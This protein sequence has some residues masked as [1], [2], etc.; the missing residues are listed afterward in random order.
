MPLAS[1]KRIRLHLDSGLCHVSLGNVCP[2]AHTKLTM[3]RFCSLHESIGSTI[4]SCMGQRARIVGVSFTLSLQAAAQAVTGGHEAVLWGAQHPPLRSDLLHVSPASPGPTAGQLALWYG[5]AFSHAP[6][7][8]LALCMQLCLR[9]QHTTM[10]DHPDAH[11]HTSAYTCAYACTCTSTHKH[12]H[13]HT[14]TPTRTHPHP[15][16][17]PDPHPDPHTHLH[18]HPHPHTN[19]HM[20][21]HMRI[22]AVH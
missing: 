16:P 20:H 12:P 18:P 14:H 3:S 1:K 19:I 13:A 21:I 10:T 6:V 2:T 17:H 7:L 5:R 11:A 9:H 15:H 22:Q 4:S 8:F